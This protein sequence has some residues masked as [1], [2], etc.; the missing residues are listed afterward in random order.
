MT[1]SRIKKCEDYITIIY[2]PVFTPG[3]IQIRV[4]KGVS[5]YVE[6]ETRFDIIFD[7]STEWLNA[8]VNRGVELTE[9]STNN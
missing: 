6:I 8:C 7:A 1:A 3:S 5:I 4:V 2:I 9:L